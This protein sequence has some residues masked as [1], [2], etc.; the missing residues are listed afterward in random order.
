M[1]SM[2]NIFL[3]SSDI[4][5]KPLTMALVGI[6]WAMP[7]RMIIADPEYISASF[8]T[9]VTLSF[10]IRFRQLEIAAG[11]GFNAFFFPGGNLRVVVLEAADFPPYVGA[12]ALIE[13]Q[14]LDELFIAAGF[15]ISF[16]E[17]V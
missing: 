7:H 10:Y 1:V 12:V 8:I 15:N 9:A 2:A 5:P 4:S 14:Q 11:L 16:D 6:I 3:L 13:V 17:Y